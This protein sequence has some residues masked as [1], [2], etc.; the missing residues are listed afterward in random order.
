ML[1]VVSSGRRVQGLGFRVWDSGIRVQILG[2]VFRV[3]GSKV[4]VQDIEFS[5]YGSG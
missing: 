2:L 5:V 3:W 4:R 1:A